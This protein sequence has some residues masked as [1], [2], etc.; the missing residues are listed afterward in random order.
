MLTSKL[1]SRVEKRTLKYAMGTTPS[2][3][4]KFC[5]SST[6]PP[7]ELNIMGTP[8]SISQM[9]A[10]YSEP[11]I[12]VSRVS[13]QGHLQRSRYLTHIRNTA[14]IASITRDDDTT[15]INRK[16]I[17]VKVGGFRKD[18]SESDALPSLESELR[19]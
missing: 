5:P 8:F 11:L 14:H 17:G 15:A 3:K 9:S 4:V 2:S 13:N 16:H 6:K 7:A 1:I 18:S 10:A 12:P 19:L